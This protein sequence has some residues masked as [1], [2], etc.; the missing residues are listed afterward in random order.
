[1]SVSLSLRLAVLLIALAGLLPSGCG[2]EGAA[3]TPAQSVPVAV[4]GRV[5][6]I[7]DG[8]TITVRT[9]AGTLKIRLAGI[10]APE[11]RQPYGSKAKEAL[12]K[13]LA[14]REV[15]LIDEGKDVYG[16][17]LAR[18]IAGGIDVNAAMVRQGYAWHFV[19]YDKSADLAAAEREARKA[20]RGLWADDSP[21][22]PWTFRKR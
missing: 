16:R 10:D 8:D 12:G 17:T 13:M 5:V 14:G 4:A 2:G 21:V 18:V 20:K 9:A 6:G 3:K 1:M 19:K 7:T 22:P 15:R 11:K